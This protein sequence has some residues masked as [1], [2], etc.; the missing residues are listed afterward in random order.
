V[1]TITAITADGGITA[2]AFVCSVSDADA[3][4]Y[5]TMSEILSGVIE[6]YEATKDLTIESYLLS[7]EGMF[8]DAG[9]HYKKMAADLPYVSGKD[10]WLEYHFGPYLNKIITARAAFNDAQLGGTK[11]LI[12]GAACL[13][14]LFEPT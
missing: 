4:A 3:H 13:R 2:A 7:A 12:S 6:N 11:A 10:A 14:C 9:S 1:A 8:L 5:W